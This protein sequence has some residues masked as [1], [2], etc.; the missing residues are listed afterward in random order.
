MPQANRI[1]L[2]AGVLINF[3]HK[4][5]LNDLYISKVY[6]HQIVREK[7]QKGERAYIKEKRKETDLYDFSLK[8]Y[9]MSNIL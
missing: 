2:Q 7:K 8:S 1:L 6:N 9:Q 4:K 5:K 3:R